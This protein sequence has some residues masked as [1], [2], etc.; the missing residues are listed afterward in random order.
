MSLAIAAAIL[1]VPTVAAARS[2]LPS[3]GDQIVLSGSL[4]VQKGRSV[5]E[6]VVLHGGVRI[7]GVAYGDVV[8]IDGG[9]SIYGQVSG[10]VIAVNGSVYLGPDAQVRGDVIARDTVRVETGAKVAG[11][12][13]EHAAFTWRT[14]ARVFGHLASWL[15]V[16][17]STLALGMLLILVAPRG[18]DAVFDAARTSPWTSLGW[19]VAAF[20]GLPLL[21]IL[22]LISLVGLPFGLALLLAL[23]LLFSVGYAYGAW[24]IGRLLWRPPR[25]RALAV[26]L[27]WL[28]VRV[29]ALAPVVSGISWAL[30]AVFGLGAMTVAVWRARQAGGKHREGRTTQVLGPL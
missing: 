11:S 29:I 30:G 5:D 12:I 15:A 6:V 14:P 1:G 4:T 26:L 20:V 21:G 24:T 22:A 2:A 8:V 28:F 17:V 3:E 27:G 16:T 7:L 13:R 19:G 18:A 9:I 10:S 23:A 25:N